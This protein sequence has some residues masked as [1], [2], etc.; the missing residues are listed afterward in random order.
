[1]NRAATV[2]T[3]DVDNII[4]NSSYSDSNI[5]NDLTTDCLNLLPAVYAKSN[6]NNYTNLNYI[7][8][9]EIELKNWAVS[10]KIA[11]CH[12]NALLII[13]RK[14][15]GFE[16]PPKDSRTLLQTPIVY[17]DQIRLVNPNCKY[18]HF[19]LPDTLQNIIQVIMFRKKQH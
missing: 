8:T 17:T 13:L 5:L 14:Y 7:K 1:M 12:L 10:C 11:Q 16:K 9:I 4:S 6:E 3:S 19:G 2:G 15:K 18:F